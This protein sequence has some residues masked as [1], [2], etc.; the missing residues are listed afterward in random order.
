M[1]HWCSANLQPFVFCT[2][3]YFIGSSKASLLGAWR[4]SSLVQLLSA[5]CSS[6]RADSYTCWR[7]IVVNINLDGVGLRHSDSVMGA[8]EE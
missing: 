3:L 7:Y 6:R 2:V 8:R 4:I 5:T 1:S